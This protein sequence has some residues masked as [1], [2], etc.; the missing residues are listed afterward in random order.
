MQAGALTLILLAL[1][2]APTEP[3]EVPSPASALIW[4]Y[5]GLVR[6][7]LARGCVYSPSCS[8]Y[9]EE[10]VRSRGLIFG[11]AMAVERW[12]RCHSGAR[13]SG[14]YTP[15]TRGAL[16]DPPTGYLE[17][18]GILSWSRAALPF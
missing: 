2:T 15:D 8:H 4:Q 16:I 1:A 3:E 9:A 14:F 5:R 12:T 6:D 13:E 7:V 10:A 17:E 11:A 18:G